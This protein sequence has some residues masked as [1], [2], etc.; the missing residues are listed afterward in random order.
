MYNIASKKITDILTEF[1]EKKPLILFYIRCL[2][3]LIKL[4]C[5]YD[6]FI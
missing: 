1:T 6:I 3:K 4:D 5:K 2:L